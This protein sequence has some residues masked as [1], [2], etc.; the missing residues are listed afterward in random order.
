MDG[1]GNDFSGGA[2]PPSHGGHAGSTLPPS[3]EDEPPPYSDD[4]APAPPAFAQA[5]APPTYN[6]HA[7]QVAY[8]APSYEP[9]HH[10]GA[11]QQPGYAPQQP[12]MV[13]SAAMASQPQQT[14][15]TVIVNDVSGTDFRY[16]L[17]IFLVGWL[18]C[19]CIWLGNIAF[20]RSQDP[21]ARYLSWAS[22]YLYFCTTGVSPKRISFPSPTPTSL[23]GCI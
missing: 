14:T 4:F 13:P 10:P 5:P 15:T 11:Y 8:N 3:F 7:P 1:R 19:C 21:N 9:V 18:G 2:V 23:A 16:A 17:V 6:P 20:V 22:L 12:V